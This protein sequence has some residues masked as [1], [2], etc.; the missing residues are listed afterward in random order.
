MQGASHGRKGIGM[1]VEIA[2]I[3]Q[4]K[5]PQHIDRIGFKG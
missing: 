5:Q 1:Q 2:L 3:G 4:L